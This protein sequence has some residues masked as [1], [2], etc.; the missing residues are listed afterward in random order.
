MIS[1]RQIVGLAVVYTV[2]VAAGVSFADVGGSVVFAVA[3]AWYA[4]GR[5]IGRGDDVPTRRYRWGRQ[6]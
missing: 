2:L 6:K 5:M 3:F 1:T 4:V